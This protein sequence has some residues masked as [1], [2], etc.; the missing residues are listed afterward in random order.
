MML[1]VSHTEKEI[2]RTLEVFSEALAIV[3]DAIRQNKVL[4]W[5]EGEVIQPV[6]RSAQT[7]TSKMR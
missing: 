1:S 7:A 4:D 2:D 5:L 6:I 3:K